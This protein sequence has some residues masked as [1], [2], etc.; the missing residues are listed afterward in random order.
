MTQTFLPAEVIEH[1]QDDTQ[2]SCIPLA[3]SAL[4]AYY[5]SPEFAE[6]LAAHESWKAAAELYKRTADDDPRKRFYAH[7]VNRTDREQNDRLTACRQ[8][9]V[10]VAA[11]G[12]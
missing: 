9:S 10:H 4:S 8:A 3:G 12:W 7:V 2:I 1:T 11:F 5:A 6:Y